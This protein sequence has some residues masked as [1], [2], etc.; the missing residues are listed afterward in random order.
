MKIFF[1]MC[2][3]C[4]SINSF[5]GFFSK[6]LTIYRC[7]NDYSSI[8]ACASTCKKDSPAMKIEFK[9]NKEAKAVQAIAFQEGKQSGSIFI[10]N[11]IIFDEKN[12][13][14]RPYEDMLGS[15]R[16]TNGIYSDDAIFYY[17]GTGIK[18][19]PP[20]NICAK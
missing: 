10:E 3:I 4:Y 14:C 2:C 11:C 9:V 13:K 12:W 1:F 7:P 6:K 15:K 19:S 16:M 8:E 17:P 20:S 5:A 18:P